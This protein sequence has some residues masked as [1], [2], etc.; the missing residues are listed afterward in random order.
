M[1]RKSCEKTDAALA[2]KLL[3][4]EC[5]GGRSVF[6]CVVDDLALLLILSAVTYI[7][8]RPHFMNR[9]AAFIV[10]A[11]SAAIAALTAFTVLREIRYRRLIKL[12][13]SMK[14][15][16]VRA[17]L[18]LRPEVLREA[19]ANKEGCFAPMH[20]EALTADDVLEGY[21]LYGGSCRLVSYAEPTEK[22]RKLM[23]LLGMEDAVSPDEALGIRAEELVKVSE[24]ELA[25]AAVRLYGRKKKARLH[26]LILAMRE[27]AFKFMLLGAALFALSFA[28]R[29]T[30]MYRAFAALSMGIA[31]A[32]Y[33]ADRIKERAKP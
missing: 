26:L 16:L 15:S 25:L 22:A 14:E 3:K 17:K 6:A 31:S 32:V 23:K 12:R 27:R 9:T 4:R 33:A 10:T 21:R 20:A 29:Y 28:V 8:V 30:L 11:V 1:E 2:E 24:E 7:T 13:K 5:R 18:M 19:L